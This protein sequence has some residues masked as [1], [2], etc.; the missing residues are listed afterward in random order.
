MAKTS[1]AM[2]RSSAI[3]AGGNDIISDGFGNEADLSTNAWWRSL[4]S[5]IPESQRKDLYYHSGMQESTIAKMSDMERYEYAKYDAVTINE[6]LPKITGVSQKQID[7]AESIRRREIYDVVHDTIKRAENAA[8]NESLKTGKSI[9]EV[10][11]SAFKKA[12]VRSFS[13]FIFAALRQSKFY[14]RLKKWTS[15]RDIIDG[16]LR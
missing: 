8:R 6:D 4:T 7:Y 11:D 10:K 9:R 5:G 12:G 13:D 1:S 16:N 2:R 14:N 15:A 3:G